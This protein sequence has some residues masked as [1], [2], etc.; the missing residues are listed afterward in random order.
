MKNLL[1]TIALFTSFLCSAQTIRIANNNANAPTGDNIYS[2]VQAAIDA[3]SDDDIIQVV[4]S[5]SVYAENIVIDKKLTIYGI[6]YNPQSTLTYVSTINNISIRS[7]KASG[8]TISGIRVG[9]STTD[10]RF[11]GRIALGTVSGSTETISD[12]TIERCQFSLIY[13]SATMIIDGLK[14]INCITFNNT[15][16]AVSLATGTTLTN[17]VIANC[18]LQ[19]FSFPRSDIG[20][21]SAGNFAVIK[22]NLFLGSSGWSAGS[23]AGLNNCLVSDNIFY[24]RP[25]TDWN[26]SNF[27]LNTFSNNISFAV[28]AGYEVFPPPGVPQANF[29]GLGN[30]ENTDPM[31]TR[32]NLSGWTFSNDLRL[33]P[34]SEAIGA[35]TGGTD[36]G[37]L[38]GDY[39]FILNDNG[40]PVGQAIPTIISVSIPA[41]VNEGEDLNA[42]INAKGN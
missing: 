21:L 32:V 34:G 25:P 1:L 10:A 3:A 2:T 17:A 18:I 38:G 23:F 29:D 8:T 22:N 19:N 14:I 16:L 37:P 26:P 24:G 4:P 6:G 30:L 5:P 40:S 28:A 41:L 36:I 20:I 9:T 39:P 27:Q 11:F 42:V 35:G 31:F 12:I 15:S 13:Q 7:E 33:L